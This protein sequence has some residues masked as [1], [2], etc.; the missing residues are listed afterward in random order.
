M[1]DCCYFSAKT[2]PY[3]EKYKP[4]TNE[5]HGSLKKERISLIFITSMGYL[6]LLVKLYELGLQ[7][8]Q[9]CTWTLEC[10]RIHEHY[11]LSEFL[12]EKSEKEEENEEEKIHLL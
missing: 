12:F 10:R 3:I 6:N 5:T 9:I 2:G 8:G 1:V 7:L 11:I 4:D